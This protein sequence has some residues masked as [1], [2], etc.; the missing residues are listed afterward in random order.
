MSPEVIRPD[1]PLRNERESRYYFLVQLANQEPFDGEVFNTLVK[2][3]GEKHGVSFTAKY[4]VRGETMYIFSPKGSHDGFDN[5]LST[6]GV[7]EELVGAGDM[8]II[9]RDQMKKRTIKSGSP[10]LVG[11]GKLTFMKAAEH[12]DQTIMPLLGEHFTR[13]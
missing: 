11:N 9:D 6:N 12:L 8:S 1:Q 3:I 2:E 5:L 4:I 13:A 10:S 7:T